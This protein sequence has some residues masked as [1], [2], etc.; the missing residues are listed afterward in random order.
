MT[1]T[2]T[3]RRCK[4][5]AALAEAARDLSAAIDRIGELQPTYDEMIGHPPVT[6]KFKAFKAFEA[7]TWGKACHALDLAENRMGEAMSA[8]GTVA[9]VVHGRLYVDTTRS[10]GSQ[11]VH[12]TNDIE[13]FNF[14]DVETL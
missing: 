3:A 5:H 14:A 8:T 1:A 12:H 7:D 11:C 13:T 9:V 4:T 2:Q 6:P 10:I